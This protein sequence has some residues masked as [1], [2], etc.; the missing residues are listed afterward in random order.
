M[1][2]AADFMTRIPENYAARL[3]EKEAL[4]VSVSSKEDIIT[5]VKKLVADNA[6]I[7]EVRNNAG[8]E[9]WFMEITKN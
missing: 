6:E 8:L 2:N 5:L 3:I 7:F 4:E 9:D 1:H